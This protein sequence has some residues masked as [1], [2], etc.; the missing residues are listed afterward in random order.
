MGV[1]AVRENIYGELVNREMLHLGGIV[2]LVLD[3]TLPSPV[4]TESFHAFSENRTS[5]CC[6]EVACKVDQNFFA[7]FMHYLIAKCF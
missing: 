5:I 7:K 2:L 4:G 1:R 3:V 6:L